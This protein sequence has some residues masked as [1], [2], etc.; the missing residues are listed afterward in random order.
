LQR[1]QNVQEGKSHLKKRHLA[2]FGFFLSTSQQEV[3]ADIISKLSCWKLLP[4]N[5]RN[6]DK[7][8][9]HLAAFVYVPS[10]FWVEVSNS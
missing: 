2:D 5:R 3:S 9:R 1:T 4:K 6:K 10:V 7:K 8:K